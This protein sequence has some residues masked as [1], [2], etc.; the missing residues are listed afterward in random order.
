VTYP[1]DFSV[2]TLNGANGFKISGQNATDYAGASVASA[3]DING[4]GFDDLIIG[5]P[6]ADPN[7]SSSG[8]AYVVFGKASGFASDIA[9]SSL[10]GTAGFKLTGAAAGDFTGLSVA[11]AGDINGDGFADLVIGAHGS[12]GFTGTSYVVFGKASGFGSN[13]DLAG[14]DGTSGFKVVGAAAGDDMGR[15]VATAG[16]FNG[17]GYD[18]LVLGAPY[19]D[20]NGTSS[21]ASYVIFGKAGSFGSTFDV[22][23]LDGTNGIKYSGAAAGDHAGFSAAS[24][25]DFNGDG[26]DDLVIGAELANA[27]HSGAVYVARGK[28]GTFS[29]NKDLT[30]PLWATFTGNADWEQAGHSV[31]S[32]GDLNGDGYDDLIIGAPFAGPHGINSGT[33]YVVFGR[34]ASLSGSLSSGL[35][36]KLNGATASAQAGYSVAA[37][38]DVNGDGFDDL[39]VGAPF[40]S[41]QGVYSGVDYVVFGKASGLSGTIELSSLNGTNGF[42]IGGPAGFDA[43]GR[44]VSSGD[45]NGDGFS[46][47][48]IGAMH[49]DPHGTDS[50]AAY[51]VFGQAPDTAVV[52]TGTGASQTLA[53]G[54][55]NDTLNGLG[56]NDKLYGNGGDDTL[57]GG[58]GNDVMK[59]GD[60]NDTYYVDSAGDVVFEAANEGTDTVHTT[61]SYTLAPNVEILIADSNAGLSLTGNNLDNTITGG[62][63]NDHLVGGRGADHM[64]GGAGNDIYLVD[65]AGDV[66]TDTSG[67]DAIITKI[68]TTLGDDIEN[69]RAGSN[70]GL[71]LTGNDHGNR[72]IGADGDDT[73]TGGLGRDSL[74]G[75]A[76]DDIFKYLSIGDSGVGGAVRDVITDFSAGDKIDL[77]AIDAIDGGGHDAFSFVGSGKFTAA[78]QVRFTVTTGGDTL[79]QANTGGTNAADFS[80]LLQGTHALSAADF[81]FN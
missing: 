54:N 17:D 11:S 8:A 39:V 33:S 45:I 6:G 19:A 10:D 81:K 43:I 41:A 3:G 20:P 77:S 58:T 27:N 47:L 56:G 36:F 66:V 49:S 29:A 79:V 2:A 59:G 65:N 26:I 32:A 35:G 78:G 15:S 74:T 60:G 28:V 31:S 34:A 44:S 71:I 50:G 51:V 18:D 42:R 63:S 7:G 67:I 5:V 72:I 57:N 12:A 48:I 68:D 24:A 38:G 9:L 62:D 75:G 76:G 25:G 61:V 23:T 30:P 14:L 53:G 52:R 69:L 55:F 4:D 13:I 21:G 70:G 37:A 22:T 73:L 1:A 64:N 40:A 16:D 46:D 80:I